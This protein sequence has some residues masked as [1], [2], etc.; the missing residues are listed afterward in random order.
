M[1]IKSIDYVRALKIQRSLVEAKHKGKLSEDILF[2]LEHPGVFTVGRNKGLEN[3]L[4]SEQTLSNRGIDLVRIERGGDITYHGPGQLVVYPI[5]NLRANRLSVTQFV[6]DL[7]EVMLQ[8][9]RLFDVQAVRDSRNHGM[10]VQGKKIGSVGV[11]I[12]RGISFHGLAFNVCNSLTPFTW[13]NPCGL[14]NVQMT[15][16]QNE[17]GEQSQALSMESVRQKCKALITQCFD[18][19]LQEIDLKR[20][21]DYIPYFNNAG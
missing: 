7:E 1:D 9:C 11:A 8:L 18:V 20:V 5:V 13:I 21:E 2:V 6:F 3:L 14:S 4:V 15:S 12:R 17:L 10:W 16:L 19:Q